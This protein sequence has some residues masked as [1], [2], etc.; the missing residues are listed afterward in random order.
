[1]VEDSF[2]LR[3]QALREGQARVIQYFQL[4]VPVSPVTKHPNDEV[5]TTS[6]EL[7][8]P[9]F[10]STIA[11]SNETASLLSFRGNLYFTAFTSHE[12]F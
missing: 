6:P 4:S 1:M 3:V 12:L 11:L 8:F 5:K 2:Q 10:C 9:Q 7:R